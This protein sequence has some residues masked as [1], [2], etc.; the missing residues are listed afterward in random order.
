M[1]N[2][3]FRNYSRTVHRGMDPNGVVREDFYLNLAIVMT[4]MIGTS[5]LMAVTFPVKASDHV[6]KSVV[7]C[8]VLLFIAEDGTLHL[9][10]PGSPALP[11]DALEGKVREAMGSI[12]STAT[13]AVLRPVHLRVGIEDEVLQRIS[14]VRGILTFVGQVEYKNQ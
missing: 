11:L 14:R 13:L 7:E 6:A 4:L 3:P 9:G 5:G 1:R 10:S 12:K 8:S 2:L